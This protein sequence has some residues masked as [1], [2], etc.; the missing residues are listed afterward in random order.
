MIYCPECGT[1]N[2][3]GSNFC[4]HCGQRLQSVVVRCPMCS[5]PNPIGTETCLQCGARLKPLDLTAQ[6][7]QGAKDESES[8]RLPAEVQATPEEMTPAVETPE[9]SD[10]LARLRSI[11]AAGHEPAEPGMAQE[12]GAGT[13]SQ[14]E[15]PSQARELRPIA[16]R[17]EAEA[18]PALQAADEVPPKEAPLPAWLREIVGKEAQAEGM[19]TPSDAEA[20][21]PPWLRRIV[22]GEKAESDT[23]S[24]EHPTAPEAAIPA[25]PRPEEP[26]AATAFPEGE[27]A[28]A[29]E[30]AAEAA[31]A[32]EPQPE[33][34]PEAEK[35][36]AAQDFILEP[37]VPDWLREAAEAPAARESVSD[38]EE[39]PDWLRT[40]IT[41]E[42]GAEASLEELAAELAPSVEERETEEEISL[43]E[44]AVAEATVPKRL[45]ERTREEPA[46]VAEPPVTA[47]ADLAQGEIPKWVEEL[48]PTPERK[49]APSEEKPVEGRGILSGVKGILPI[50]MLWALPKRAEA[51][52]EISLMPQDASAGDIVADL[53]A[54]Q[55]E[56]RAL[57]SYQPG[58]A[59]PGP[60]VRRLLYL[61]LA[62]AIIVPL[63]FGADWFSQ[64]IAVSD[65]TWSMYDTINKLPPGSTVLLS[66]DYDPVTAA[67]LDLQAGAILR[68]LL[69]RDLRV[70][71]LSLVPQGPALAQAVWS[72]VAT[73]SDYIY[74]ED[75]ANLGYVPG[76]QTALRSL[77]SAFP[78]SGNDFFQAP[79]S[80]LPM[81]SGV[82][83]LRDIPL[84]IVLAGD[85]RFV[86][87]WLEQ[88]PSQIPVKVAAAVSGV[89]GP[90]VS[91]YLQSGQLVGRLVGLVG[92]AEY[93]IAINQPST[94]VA[95]LGAQSAGHI[96]VI[97]VILLG[98]VAALFTAAKRRK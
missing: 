1:A 78:P 87:A 13:T 65:T 80:S 42:K 59:M 47:G 63:L 73:G 34:P 74:G 21:V 23:I 95:S 17:E 7:T 38:E 37:A 94:A 28:P 10:W 32:P 56:G 4:N 3:D 67:E 50:E 16:E 5:T 81:L 79:L 97:V 77:V 70:V 58:A 89:V 45:S 71:A 91:P 6:P 84:V 29:E 12:T 30:V 9:P 19:S 55:P 54:A 39:I 31:T 86:R 93:E 83:G 22:E 64:T 69:Q 44:E 20:Q 62:L 2:P 85:Q 60:W 66:F 76:E 52:P 49:A 25:E 96:L 11:A 72:K 43:P 61:L 15:S 26:E 57:P 92:A 41:P 35:P 24:R 75:F 82:K 33:I 90:A 48:R 46:A 88:V 40:M 18:I 8:E 27:L 51:M 98:N 53:L 68:H 14:E 36:L